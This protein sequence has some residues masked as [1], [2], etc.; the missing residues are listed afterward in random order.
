MTCV[1]GISASQVSKVSRLARSLKSLCEDR[2]RN[3][4]QHGR[5]RQNRRDSVKVLRR[6]RNRNGWR[7][8]GN[9]FF[10]LETGTGCLETAWRVPETG[11][12]FLKSSACISIYQSI[13]FCATKKEARQA[14]CH[15]PGMLLSGLL[16]HFIASFIGYSRLQID[17]FS[18]LILFSARSAGLD[19]PPGH[20]PG[21]NSQDALREYGFLGSDRSILSSSHRFDKQAE[22][23]PC[24]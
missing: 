5:H 1:T 19:I 8:A 10:K 16:F 22:Q 17:A 13:Q 21:R 24:F 9:G 4:Y 23:A 3:R 2:N 18:L 11:I 15:L 7:G 12:L 20:Q 6:P 14:T